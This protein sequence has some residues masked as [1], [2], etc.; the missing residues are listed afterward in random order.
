L[1]VKIV[2]KS[3]IHE[4][5][6]VGANKRFK[7]IPWNK[8]AGNKLKK[9]LTESGWTARISKEEAKRSERAKKL[10]ELG[11]EFEAP[12]LKTVH[13]VKDDTAAIEAADEEAPKAIE[14]AP[15]PTDI[16]I[17]E[18]AQVAKKSGKEDKKP[19]T[20]PGKKGKKGKKAAS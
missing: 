6:W 10:A 13:D 17:G 16:D 14:A 15:Q 19:A 9:P 2:P 12:K 3:Q 11:Y 7:Q 18:E 1:K 8:M 20:K 4:K 5:L